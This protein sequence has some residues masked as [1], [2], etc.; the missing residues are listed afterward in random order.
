M[1]HTKDRCWK[2]NGKS[3]STSANF[4]EIMV[5][6]GEATLAKLNYLCGTKHNIFFGVRMH[7]RRLPMQAS[8]FGVGTKEALGKESREVGNEG[9]ERNIR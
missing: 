5:D 3:P 8:T 2:K 7:K 1:G 4:L 6:D 9:I